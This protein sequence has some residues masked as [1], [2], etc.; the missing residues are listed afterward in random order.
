M[1]L[2]LL[3]NFFI[4]L[5]PFIFSFDKRINFFS[6]LKSIVYSI[7][8]T[9]GLFALW[10]VFAAFRTHWFFNPDYVFGVYFLTLPI[11]EWLFFVTVPFACLFVFES[12]NVLVKDKI[13]FDKKNKLVSVLPYVFAFLL[14]VSSFLFL[15]KEYTF[16]AIL[17]SGLMIVLIA[18]F[19]NLFYRKLYWIYFGLTLGLFLIFNY[20]LTSIPIITYNSSMILNFRVTTIPLEDFFFNFAMLSLL[21]FCYTFFEKK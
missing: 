9:G 7:L 17:A 4:I 8:I 19:S 6:K 3:I 2:Y 15:P 11:E 21:V 16:L 5:F 20:I 1:S 14:I 10:D 13:V 12:L 18:K